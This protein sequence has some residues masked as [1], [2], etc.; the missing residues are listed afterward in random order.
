MRTAGWVVVIPVKR[1]DTAKSRLR[2][3]V[4]ASRHGDLA[5]AL[6]LDTI[7][8]VRACPEVTE[9][10]LVTDEP[11]LTSGAAELGVRAVPDPAGGLNAALRFG[12][13]VC[14]GPAR[15]RAALTGDLPA[16]RPTELAE[17]LRA[18]AGRQPTGGVPAGRSAAVGP[19]RSFVRDAAGSGTVLLA[20]DA[21]VAL[22][23][24]FGVDS[25]V[26]H[27]RSGAAELTGAWPGL[28]QDVDTPA[29][30][31]AV[32][33]AGVGGLTRDL[34]R[35]LGLTADCSAR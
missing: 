29:D 19:R 31:R 8:A 32:L 1:L 28:R 12:A 14:A 33:G 30:L 2:G 34:A 11:A 5:L 7:A 4:R 22:E 16:L 24:W 9:V 23:P 27:A 6:V 10:L 21:G 35:D 25:A 15:R 3:A 26:A 13:D 20:A 17:A 18:A